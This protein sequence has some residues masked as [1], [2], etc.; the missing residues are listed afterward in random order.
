MSRIIKPGEANKPK[1]TIHKTKLFR[2]QKTAQ[3]IHREFGMRGRCSLCGGPPSIMVRMLAL[4]EDVKKQSMPYWVAVCQ[5]AADNG[6]VDKDG[7]IKVPFIKTT[8]GKMIRISQ[9]IACS[10]HQKD[11][12]VTAARAP[13]WVLV[14]IDRGPGADNPVVAV[15]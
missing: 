7:N 3:E 13:S 14:E 11:L 6:H 12:E 9:A 8:Y 5:S 2:G 1:R 15:N 4:I 10:H